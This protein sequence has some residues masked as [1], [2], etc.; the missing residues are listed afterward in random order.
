M[1]STEQ[2]KFPRSPF[3]SQQDFEYLCPKMDEWS[4]FT[5]PTLDSGIAGPTSSAFGDFRPGLELFSPLLRPW[6]LFPPF[7]PGADRMERIHSLC[8]LRSRHKTLHS[9]PLRLETLLRAFLLPRSFSFFFPSP[10]PPS[11]NQL[12]FLLLAVPFSRTLLF[13]PGLLFPGGLTS[14]GVPESSCDR[15]PYGPHC[16]FFSILLVAI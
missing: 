14:P 8:G 1:R 7:V 13:L 12:F 15:E 16:D 2:R 11:Y 4:R 5:V 9:I 10:P 6:S 3:S